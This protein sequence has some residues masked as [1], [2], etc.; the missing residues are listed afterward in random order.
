MPIKMPEMPAAVRAALKKDLPK[1]AT[2]AG[3]PTGEAGAGS[4][5]PSITRRS[6]GM[7]HSLEAALAEGGTA[8][9]GAPVT[10][11]GLDQLAK[12]TSPR[13]VNA[14]LW[15]QLLPA[16]TKGERALAE[17][18]LKK[19]RLASVAEGGEVKA[20]ARR[21]DRLAKADAGR[22]PAQELAMILVPALHLVAVWL[23]GTNE[24]DDV[25]IPSDGPI[26]PLE[27][28][29]RYGMSEF[30]A[31]VKTMAEQRIRATGDAEGG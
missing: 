29:K 30:Q 20:L 4:A 23:K 18:D 9:V 17:V 26:S 15:A 14:S 10:V 21:V 28:G 6:R 22:G 7:A 24:Q 19:K 31:I 16:G 3:R 1:F 2:A 27:P 12:G 25:V 5:R 13:R 11:L 8:G